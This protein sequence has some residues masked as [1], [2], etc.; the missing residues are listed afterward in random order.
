MDTLSWKSNATV[1]FADDS[2]GR[3]EAQ[4]SAGDRTLRISIYSSL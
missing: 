2:V 3:I 4:K 1:T